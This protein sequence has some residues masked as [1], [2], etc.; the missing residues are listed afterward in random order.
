MDRKRM[1]RSSFSNEKKRPNSRSQKRRT[2]PLLAVGNEFNVKIEDIGHNGDGLVILEG[3][4]VF[5][6]NTEKNE[7]VKIKITKVMKTIAKAIRLN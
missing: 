2:A 4:T 1:E 7:E 5:V 6:K 3:Y